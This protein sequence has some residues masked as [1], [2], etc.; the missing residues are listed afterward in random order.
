MRSHLFVLI[1]LC[2]LLLLLSY[3]TVANPSFGEEEDEERGTEKNTKS[4]SSSSR[5]SNSS[6]TRQVSPTKDREKEY[7]PCFIRKMFI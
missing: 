6:N 1:T 2:L 4:S 7:V 5:A 3:P